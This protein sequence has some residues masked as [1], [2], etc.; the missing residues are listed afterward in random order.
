MT[1][2]RT[3]PVEPTEEMLVAARGP[4][5][6]Q[7]HYN[8]GLHEARLI[9]KAMIAAAPQPPG[10]SCTW[11]EDPDGNWGTECDEMF[12]FTTGGPQEN[13]MKFCCYCGKPLLERSFAEEDYEDY[14]E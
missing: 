9:Y 1:K 11:F 13:D 7:P 2:Y 3:V 6:G 10:E 4:D 5:E 8:L 12:Q 14:E